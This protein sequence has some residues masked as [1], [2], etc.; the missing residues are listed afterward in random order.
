MLHRIFPYALLTLAAMALGSLGLAGPA[1]A[2]RIHVCQYPSPA[3]PAAP[4]GARPP[5]RAITSTAAG[6][7][8]SLA[9][10]RA[11]RVLAWGTNR[12]GQ[13]GDGTRQDRARP[14][15][16]RGP[17]GLRY[18]EDVVA[19][20]AG[21]CHG[22]ALLEDGRVAAWGWNGFG[23]VG[24]GSRAFWVKTPVLVRG[25]DGRGTLQGVMQVAAGAKHSLALLQDGAVVAWGANDSQ[26]LGVG[27]YRGREAPVRV[28][29]IDGKGKLG[30]VASVAAGTQHS[31]AV[32]LDGT[33]AAWGSNLR[34]EIGNGRSHGY[35]PY[36][37][38]VRSL[39]GDDGSLSGVTSV[40]AGERFSI[41]RLA[42][43]SLAA[44][45][46][47]FYGELGDGTRD[48]RS[49]PV[50][51]HGVGDT[52]VLTGVESVSAGD[53]SFVLAL[54]ED[55]GVIAWGRGNL[56]Q[57]GDGART[58]FASL[59]R[60]VRGVRGRPAL[61]NVTHIAAG[62]NHSFAVRRGTRTVVGWGRNLYHQVDAS[63]VPIRFVPVAVRR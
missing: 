26:Q 61:T 55:G 52:P 36:P 20:A 23:Q 58:G 9:I 25:I 40:T 51:V 44:W 32:L 1:S 57:L 17:G 18:L 12:Y 38:R 47:N 56:G 27:G 45:G 34:G 3:Q 21:V 42:N 13:L 24:N 10:T 53:N 22:L 49:T 50:L 29:G 16:V 41:A 5:L 37:I 14:V 28:L 8:F 46:W 30:A 4:A 6:G 7:D 59:P 15:F 54:L 35:Q 2:G 43:G 33:V 48:R 19:V 39:S 63:S 62:A 31:L 60:P 11:G